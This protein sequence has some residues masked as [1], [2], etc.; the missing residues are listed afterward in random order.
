MNKKFA[1]QVAPVIDIFPDLCGVRYRYGSIRNK[2]E[3][4]AGLGYKRI[5]LV[6]S[7]PGQPMYSNPWLSVMKPDTEANNYALESIVNIGDPVFDH[8]YEAHRAGLEAFAVVKP[9]EGGGGFT[10]PHG[11]TALFKGRSLPCIGGE[12]VGFDTF[13]QDHGEMRVKRKP[14]ERYDERVGQTITRITLTFCLDRVEQRI[15]RD[16]T[17]VFEAQPDDSP[18]L[19]SLNGLRLWTSADNGFY[20]PYEGEWAVKETFGTQELDDANGY[21]LDGGPK[22]CR[23]VEL[24]ELRIGAEHR[25]VAVSMDTGQGHAVMIPFSMIQAFGELGEVPITVSPYVR[26]SAESEERTVRVTE[27]ETGGYWFDATYPRRGDQAPEALE[28]FARNGFEFEWYGTGSWGQGWMSVPLYGIAR[29]KMAYMKGTPCEA[30]A[31]VRDY[32]L[33]QVH[34]LV[35]MGIDGVDLRLQNHSGMISDF[36]NYGYNEPLVEAYKREYGIDI[37]LEDADPIKLMRIRGQFYLQFVEEASKTLR[38]HGKTLQIHLRDSFDHPEV[39]GEFGEAGFWAMPKVLP[40]WEKL[41]ELADEITIKDYNWAVYRS[42]TA[43]RMKDRAAELGKPLW[44]HCYIAQG[45]DLNADFVSGVEQDER[46]TGMLL[47]EMGHNP[48]AHNPWI[49][50]IEVKPDGSAVFNDDVKGKIEALLGHRA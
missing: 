29:G 46:V 20:R 22:R 39:S 5:Y 25:Y 10:V 38:A 23:V 37:L 1:K 8:I 19:P 3:Q 42:E 16:K 24:T 2:M 26:M 13:L 30:Y 18:S 33:D 12:R 17:E 31:E 43:T 9:Y 41:A 36:V 48:Y 4:L 27:P 44:V 47:Y 7:L 11:R 14:I 21:P 49:G 6:V 28:R 50:L 32:W 35:A 34:R 45:G 40:D 15:H